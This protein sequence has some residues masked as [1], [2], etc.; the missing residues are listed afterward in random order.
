MR[1]AAAIRQDSATWVAG[2]A[3]GYCTQTADAWEGDCE[4]GLQGSWPLRSRDD[5]ASCVARCAACARCRYA[6]FSR[7]NGE[8]SWYHGCTFGSLNSDGV[9]GNTYTTYRMRRAAVDGMSMALEHSAQAGLAFDADKGVHGTRDPM[10][11]VVS[12]YSRGLPYD[13]GLALGAHA[14]LLEAAFAGHADTFRAYVPDQLHAMVLTTGNV[15]VRGSLTV[16]PSRVV[17]SNNPGQA[18]IGHLAAKPFLM[19][20]RLLE[21][22]EG[23][24]VVWSDVNVFK[25]PHL[26][27]AARGIKRTALWTMERAQT[28]QDVWMP[29]E[30]DSKRIAN[31]CKA[32][33]VRQLVPPDRREAVF[34]EHSN[35]AHQLL[36]RKSARSVEFLTQW[37]HACLRPELLES[38]PNPRPHPRYAVSSSFTGHLNI[39][40]LTSYIL[41]LPLHTASPGTHTSNVSSQSWQ[42]CR[43]TPPSCSG[44]SASASSG[45]PRGPLSLGRRVRRTGGATPLKTPSACARGCPSAPL[46]LAT[47]WQS[48]ARISRR[49]AR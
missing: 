13:G 11:H 38:K 6:S 47:A 48:N 37:L 23:D 17:A 42:R 9:G 32:Y 29:Y 24:Y 14:A 8:C 25:H 5:W 36:V 44:S 27:A 28:S 4:A 19:L 43:Q 39:L 18:A 15:T 46:P 1:S 33:A 31:F 20:H 10:V 12:M 45:L 7:Y 49:A 41:Y 34:A 3:Q 22:A 16:K 26:L 35:Y 40:Y 30:G 2:H 21:V